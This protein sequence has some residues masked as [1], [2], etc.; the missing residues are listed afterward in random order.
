MKKKIIFAVCLILFVFLAPSCSKTCK[1]CKKVY[2]TN[3]TTWDH[4]D[5]ASE[6]CGVE[7]AGI[8]AIGPRT[9]GAYTVKWECN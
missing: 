3:L 6:Y 5:P 8:E 4:E 2:Y 7:L 1:T 9:I